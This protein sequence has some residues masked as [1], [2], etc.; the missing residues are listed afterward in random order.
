M[1]C[2]KQ[3]GLGAA[4][5]TLAG[6]RELDSRHLAATSGRSAT[7]GPC[8]AQKKVRRHGCPK[9]MIKTKQNPGAQKIWILYSEGTENKKEPNDLN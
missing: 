1:G 3:E 7:S 4:G 9:N 6:E 2:L 8:L 5:G